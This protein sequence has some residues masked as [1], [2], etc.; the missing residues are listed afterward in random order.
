M[1]ILEEKP[2]Q[3][4]RSV[5]EQYYN[6]LC[7][8]AYSFLKDSDSSEDIVQEVFIKIWENRKDLI[9]SNSIRFYLYTAVRNNCFTYLEKNKRTKIIPI[10]D[11]D[12]SEDSSP[13]DGESGTDYNALLKQAIDQLPPKCRE[14]FLLN[15]ISKQSYQEVA[16]QLNISVKTVENQ[17]GKA[18]RI[19]RAF[20]KAY[21]P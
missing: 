21:H 9:A 15:R 3:E 5:F 2:Y 8:Y 11:Q 10:T 1:I 7:N 4:F 18:L 14:V 6:P 13:L 20:A 19:L 16:D 17:I 12:V